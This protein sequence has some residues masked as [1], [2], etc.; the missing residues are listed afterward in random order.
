MA[1]THLSKQ[2]ELFLE[3]VELIYVLLVD[4]F[5]IGLWLVDLL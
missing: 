2:V 4:G 3:V 1:D 5:S